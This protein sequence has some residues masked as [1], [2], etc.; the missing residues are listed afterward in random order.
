MNIIISYKKKSSKKK[1]LINRYR[2]S[3]QFS[4]MTC[5]H[6]Y[7]TLS[8]KPFI[9][10]FLSFYLAF[11]PQSKCTQIFY[12]KTPL[13]QDRTLLTYYMEAKSY[14]GIWKV[15]SL[16]SSSYSLTLFYTI[17]GQSNIESNCSIFKLWNIDFIVNFQIIVKHW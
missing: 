10:C 6:F 8:K 14:L 2:Y 9:F 4:I 1:K 15:V 12:Q 16:G 5:T 17:S 3:P 7:P 11:P 13:F